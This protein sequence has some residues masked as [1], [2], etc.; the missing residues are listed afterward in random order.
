MPEPSNHQQVSALRLPGID[1]TKKFAEYLKMLSCPA[2]YSTKPLGQKQKPA[3][4]RLKPATWAVAHQATMKAVGALQPLIAEE[5]ASSAL[6][7]LLCLST[8]PAAFLRAFEARQPQTWHR[9]SSHFANPEQSKGQLGS[10]PCMWN[11]LFCSD[12]LLQAESKFF[13]SVRNS[14]F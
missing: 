3:L 9:P 2:K 5:T 14:Q 13:I 8:A 11:Y 6:P 4:P 12:N 1:L 7:T 10:W